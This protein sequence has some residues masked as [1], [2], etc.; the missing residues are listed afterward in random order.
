[1]LHVIPI[2]TTNKWNVESVIKSAL[3]Q[4]FNW[5]SEIVLEFSDKNFIHQFKDAHP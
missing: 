3:L 2:F 5:N 1:M 4:N